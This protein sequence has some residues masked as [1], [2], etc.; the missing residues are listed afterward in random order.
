MAI[1][2]PLRAGLGTR[3]GMTIN[4]LKRSRVEA[5]VLYALGFLFLP[6]AALATAQIWV[7][8]LIGVVAIIALRIPH[9]SFWPRSQRLLIM[10]L[11]LLM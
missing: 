6:V 4:T 11:A 3:S 9:E 8:A 7:L 5:Y 10:L 2:L 1:H